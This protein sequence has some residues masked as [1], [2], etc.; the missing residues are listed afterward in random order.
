VKP[1]HAPGRRKPRGPRKGPERGKGSE[2]ATKPFPRTDPHDIPSE[3]RHKK[4]SVNSEQLKRLVGVWR[5]GWYGKEE[6][7]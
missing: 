4:F 2:Q 6:L 3:K 7:A 5:P 1:D